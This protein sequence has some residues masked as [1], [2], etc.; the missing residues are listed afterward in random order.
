MFPAELF[1][2]RILLK[3]VKYIE[4][5]DREPS[6]SLNSDGPQFSS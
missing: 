5:Q 6:V 1:Q 2:K 3:L 4:E